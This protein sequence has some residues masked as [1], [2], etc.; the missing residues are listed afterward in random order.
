[1]IKGGRNYSAIPGLYV[2]SRDSVRD[3]EILFDKV[4]TAPTTTTG[5]YRLYVH[6]TTGSLI[7][8]NGVAPVVI[9]AA[10]AAATTWEAIFTNDTTFAIAAGTWTI[11]QSSANAILTLNKTN[12]GA[13]TVLDITNSGTGKDIANSTNWSIIAT[14]GHGVLEL[15][16]AGTINATDG[17][18]SVGK[19]GTATTILGTLTVAEALTFTSGGVTVTSGNVLLSSGNLT[20][21]SGAFTVSAGVSTLIATSNA[22]PTLLLTNNTATTYGSGGTSTGVV[23]FRSTSL[24]TGTLARLQLTEATLNGGYYLDCWDVTAGAAVFSVAEDGVTTIAGTAGSTSFTLTAGNM[25]VSAGGL[26]ITKAADSATLSVTNDTATTASVIVLAGSGVFTGSTTTSFMTLTPSGMTSGT[27]LYMPV[28][29]MDTGRAMHIVAN[30]LTSG[31]V[32]NVTSSATAI[33]GAGRL[34]L[35]THSGATGTSA[36]LNEFISAAT[37]ETVILQVT[38]AA[39]V[40]GV[41]LSLVGTTG[42][43]TG[44]LLKASSSTAGA[45]A[46]NGIIS[47]NATGNFTSTSR[48]GFLNVSANTTTSG[49]AAHISGTAMTD[50]TILSLEAVEATLTTGLY[51][52]CYDGAANDFSVGKY[53]ATVIAGNAIGTAALTITAGDHVLTSGNLILTSGHIKNTPQA[54]VNANTAISIVTL[55]TTIANNGAST[56]TLADGTVGQLK[57]IVC[58]VYAG[59]AV[60]TPANFVGTTIT[61]NAA[62]D[63][64]L[65]VFVGTE[66]VTLSLGGTAAVA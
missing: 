12:V 22:A 34:F 13:G 23:L 5:Y 16:S 9:G 7:Y 50:G 3:A 58:T 29:A 33:T 31:I 66:W 39:M 26:A 38:S 60:I 43:T 54:I 53:G 2:I 28:A 48:A 37:D 61:L 45:V 42:M 62:G 30:A 20:L 46:T 21:T 10:G 17:A 47:L 18:L 63:S 64:W 24:T 51:I 11:T 15:G 65:G 6:P 19:T 52:Q 8:D 25:V 27:G 1:M 44:S 36:I 55:G 32:F 4:N 59:D 14:G 49:V 35:S 57:Y 41:N 40:N 56:H